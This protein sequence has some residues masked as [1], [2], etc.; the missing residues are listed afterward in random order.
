MKCNFFV[1]F[2][3]PSSAAP[4]ADLRTN[5]TAAPKPKK[6]GSFQKLMDQLRKH[7]PSKSE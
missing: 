2:S 1:C 6:G 5:I 7:F 4:T 3:F